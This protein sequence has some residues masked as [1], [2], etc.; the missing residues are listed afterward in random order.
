MD[1]AID[2]LRACAALRAL[3]GHYAHVADPRAWQDRLMQLE[4]VP[5]PELVALH[6]ELLAHEWLEQNT[7][8]VVKG[9]PGAVPCCYRVT[10]AGH[11]ALA[12]SSKPRDDEECAG[13]TEAAWAT[14]RIP[15][16]DSRVQ[17]GI[18]APER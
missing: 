7:G 18:L 5:P 10:R 8:V 9:A 17:P 2:R 15:V 13:A 3:L 4:G 14:G 16:V 1:D 6:G 12:A 11:R